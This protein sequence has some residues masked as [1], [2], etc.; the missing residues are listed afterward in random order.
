MGHPVYISKSTVVF[1]QF[2]AA[3][4]RGPK[5]LFEP[6]KSLSYV[7]LLKLF[8]PSQGVGDFMG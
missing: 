7:I 4:Y 1:N 5:E 6:Q 8:D 2:P 3:M